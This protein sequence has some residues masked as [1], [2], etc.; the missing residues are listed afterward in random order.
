MASYR[1]VENVKTAVLFLLLETGMLGVFMSLDLLIIRLLKRAW[2][3]VFLFYRVA[4]R[5][6]IMLH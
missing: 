4:A 1:I 3:R 5:S 6:A 2:C